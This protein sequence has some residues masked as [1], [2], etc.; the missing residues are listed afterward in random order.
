MSLSH[1][2]CK[3]KKDEYIRKLTAIIFYKTDRPV[4]V[5]RPMKDKVDTN[6]CYCFLSEIMVWFPRTK[7]YKAGGMFL[8]SVCRQIPCLA[9]L[10]LAGFLALVFHNNSD[11]ATGT[12]QS[13]EVPANPCFLFC[14]VAPIPMP[15]TYFHLS[16]ITNNATC[17]IKTC[18]LLWASFSPALWLIIPFSSADQLCNFFKRSLLAILT[19]QKEKERMLKL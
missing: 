5:L 4:R 16:N 10:K 9:G 2:Q 14:C 19:C 11:D 12:R 6:K 3:K 13:S 1:F 8:Q 17:R 18:Q 7:I 15:E